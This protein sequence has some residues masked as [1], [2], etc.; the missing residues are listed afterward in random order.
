MLGL[1]RHSQYAGWGSVPLAPAVVGTGTIVQESYQSDTFVKDHTGGNM[2]LAG[3]DTSTG[4]D[5]A[6]ID[7]TGYSSLT[8]FNDRRW[9]M[10]TTFYL[11]WDPAGSAPSDGIYTF[12]AEPKF[13]QSGYTDSGEFY[14]LNCFVQIQD[15][16]LYITS[17]IET[18]TILR[19][20]V[21]LPGS[22]SDYARRWLT[23][24]Y[25]GSEDDTSFSNFSDVLDQ[26]PGVNDSIY[27]RSSI[28]DTETGELLQSLDLLKRNTTADP[29][30]GWNWQ[31]P[32]FSVYGN[33][34]PIL[35]AGTGGYTDYLVAGLGSTTSRDYKFANFWASF[36][37]MFDPVGELDT[38]IFTKY[39]KNLIGN[40]KAWYNMTMEDTV[41]VTY[42]SQ[43]TYFTKLH[44]QDLISQTNNAGLRIG[45]TLTDWNSTDIPKDRL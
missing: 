5:F 42:S 7:L 12:F 2:P 22:W 29:S 18:S 40:A 35:N 44:N 13:R 25:S 20:Y 38:S 43:S 34:L 24:I 3:Q 16:D 23:V 26:S 17:R 4:L 37:T 36:G 6:N 39:P 27:T 9:T 19:A 1:A 45:T 33:T 10:A 11:D 30:N 8:G 21:P 28:Y 14:S 15:G 32:E 41:Q 31:F